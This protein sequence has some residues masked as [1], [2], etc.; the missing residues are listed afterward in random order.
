MG[1]LIKSRYQPG[2]CAGSRA[3]IILAIFFIRE[4]VLGWLNNIKELVLILHELE[5]LQ[6]GVPI[7]RT[8]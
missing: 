4:I 2:Q 3:C 1:G 5:W 8:F 7:P 6:N